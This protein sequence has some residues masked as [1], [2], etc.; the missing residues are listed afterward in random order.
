MTTH[1]RTE[2]TVETDQVLIIRRRRSIRARCAQCGCEVDMVGPEE[3][4]ALAG[5][6]GQTLRDSAHARGWHLSEGPN[7]TA[8][9]C[10]ESLLKSK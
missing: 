2:I 10:I 8:L 4:G 3:A 5:M 1:K 7:G 9:V 6:S